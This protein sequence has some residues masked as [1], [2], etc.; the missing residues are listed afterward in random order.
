[1]R[2]TKCGY[3]SFDNLQKCRHCSTN[4]EKLA[5]FLK[6]PSVQVEAPSFL[7]T[8]LEP[9]EE[10]LLSEEGEE[11]PVS[12]DEEAEEVPLSLGEEETELSIGE[13]RQEAEENILQSV[14]L[15]EEQETGGEEPALDLGED[16]PAPALNLEEEEP[17]P[18]LDLGE[19]EPAPALNLEEEEPAP[20]LDFGEEEDKGVAE[21]EMPAALSEDSEDQSEEAPPV[22][23]LAGVQE[24]EQEEVELS[25]ADKD[26]GE[27]QKAAI[28]E[29][30]E[31]KDI[32]A[33][34]DNLTAGLE[35]I[36]LNDLMA[37][38][39][40]EEGVFG[41]EGGLDLEEEA[42][43][44]EVEKIF[45]LSDVL[46]EDEEAGE[47]PIVET[48]PASEEKQKNKGV[49]EAVAA[50]LDVDLDLEVT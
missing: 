17:A 31:L 34:G 33:P 14:E 16:E 44:D 10:V 9:E 37:S 2:C 11:E 32:S 29:G 24:E 20:A 21:T 22:E 25:L 15:S 18:A 30:M 26:E 40:G 13:E 27:E 46:T 5:S 12:S 8:L 6:G 49:E 43:D 47:P 36:D 35:E 38:E 45:D 50:D 1:M 19:G 28:P 41:T 7:A 48:G 39:D 4:L 42:D 3:I 23:A